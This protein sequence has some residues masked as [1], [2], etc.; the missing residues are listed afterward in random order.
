[1]ELNNG[2]IALSVTD[3]VVRPTVHHTVHHV[4]THRLRQQGSSWYFYIHECTRIRHPACVCQ[5]L[6][7]DGLWYC[8]SSLNHEF[9]VGL[10]TLAGY[11]FS[12]LFL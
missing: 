7:V 3:S 1:M 8:R 10:G 9:T 6:N 11:L 5:P 4:M 2:I 12:L